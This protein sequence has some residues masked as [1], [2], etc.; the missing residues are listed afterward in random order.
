MRNE[1]Y[2]HIND[3]ESAIKKLQRQLEDVWDKIDELKT[4]LDE[5]KKQVSQLQNCIRPSIEDK[6]CYD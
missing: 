1:D 6:D 4:L 3:A 5:K 2:T